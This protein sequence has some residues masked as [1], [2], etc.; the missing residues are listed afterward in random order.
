MSWRREVGVVVVVVMM[1]VKEEA[2]A[3]RRIGVPRT[4]LRA[5]GCRSGRGAVL[6]GLVGLVVGTS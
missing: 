5:W 1:A 3:A 6:V 2:V 4:S